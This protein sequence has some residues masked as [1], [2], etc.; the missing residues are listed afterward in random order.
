MSHGVRPF[1]KGPT[2]LLR[3]LTITMIIN[4]LVTGMILQ[5]GVPRPW[6]LP[7]GASKPSAGLAS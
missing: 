3:G 6:E 2:T 4:H 5:V 7:S 1:G